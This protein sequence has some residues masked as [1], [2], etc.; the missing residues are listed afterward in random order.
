MNF[1][2]NPA[3]SAA[4][5][6]LN[7]GTSS[8]TA[9][10][11]GF[12]FGVAQST[13]QQTA[14]APAQQL[15]FGAPTQQQQQQPLLQFGAA[16]PAPNAAAPATGTTAAAP[17]TLGAKLSFGQPA[18]PAAT[19]PTAAAAASAATAA[20]AAAP[21]A[22]AAAAPALST[23][24]PLMSN[25]LSLGGAPAANS[26]TV[27]AK[28]APPQASLSTGTTTTASA[29]APAAQLNFC[30][31]EEHI[32]KWTLALEEQEKTFMNQATQVNS[33]DKVLISNN[34]KIVTLSEAVEKVSMQN[35]QRLLWCLVADC[36]TD[37]L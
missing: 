33:W 17:F 31:L 6:S 10:S 13:T 4:A 23:V 2:P 15:S 3:G 12:S 14:G 18:A 1:N 16:S 35:E 34:N 8:A 36:K 21:A 22:A 24:A 37:S 30:Q 27:A 5:P 25:T 11:S 19:A 32:N 28:A 9:P 20:A 26:A 7:F 29:N